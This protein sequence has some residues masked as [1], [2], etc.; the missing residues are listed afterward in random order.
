[1]IEIVKLSSIAQM[2]SVLNFA[3]RLLPFPMIGSFKFTL[4]IFL[5]IILI[6]TLVILILYFLIIKVMILDVPNNISTTKTLGKNRLEDTGE[7]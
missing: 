4:C 1:M 5:L 2:V 7:K 3:I 6:Y